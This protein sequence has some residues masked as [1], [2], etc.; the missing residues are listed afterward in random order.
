MGKIT[1]HNLN[2]KRSTE[3]E[4]IGANVH[5]PNTTCIKLFMEAHIDEIVFKQDNAS[6]IRMGKWAY[7]SRTK[8][9]A[10]Q[11]SLFLD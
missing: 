11:R 10:Y 2:T 5:I 1:K 3:T 4:L 8:I 9:K 7:F 6:S